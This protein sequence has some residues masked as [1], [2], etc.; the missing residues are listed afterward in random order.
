MEFSG[1]L[2]EH[3]FIR[4][5]KSCRQPCRVVHPGLILGFCMTLTL[6]VS[7]NRMI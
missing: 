4:C 2:M 5:V 3:M 1:I 7:A 6:T